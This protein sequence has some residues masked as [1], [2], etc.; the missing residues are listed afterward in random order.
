M[1]VIYKNVALRQSRFM[2][3][4]NTVVNGG[5][6]GGVGKVSRVAGAAG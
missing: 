5:V 4:G 6:G 1:T 2:R 3:C